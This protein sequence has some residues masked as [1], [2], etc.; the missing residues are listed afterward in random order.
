[1][2]KRTTTFCYVWFKFTVVRTP[3]GTF[4]FFSISFAKSRPT[5]P[6]ILN[7]LVKNPVGEIPRF[8]FCF[9]VG[10]IPR[11]LFLFLRNPRLPD[12][13]F[14]FWVYFAEHRIAWP[15]IY[16]EAKAPSLL[17]EKSC[18]LTAHFILRRHYCDILSKTKENGRCIDYQLNGG[19]S[20]RIFQIGGT[21]ARRWIFQRWVPTLV[22]WFV[23]TFNFLF[24]L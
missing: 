12:I 20:V 15:A 11:A 9:C 3:L 23:V 24:C 6:N 10:E 5:G 19:W 18:M 1:M 13:N 2:C 8:I 17:S 21:W 4:H 22:H 7:P 14:A 16:S